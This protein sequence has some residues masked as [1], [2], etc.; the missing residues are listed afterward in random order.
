MSMVTLEDGSMSSK[1]G[2]LPLQCI[3][4]TSEG[5]MTLSQSGRH[6]GT[7]L[8][9]D[10]TV[11]LECGSICSGR[12]LCFER[13]QVG[14]EDGVLGRQYHAF[15]GLCGGFRHRAACCLRR[16]AMYCPSAEESNMF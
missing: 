1:G 16:M 2:I 8:S 3:M 4:W 6:V 15:K 5:V 9:E 13:W 11:S 10:S 14:L 12:V 7:L